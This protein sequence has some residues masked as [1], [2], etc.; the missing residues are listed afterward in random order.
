MSNNVLAIPIPNLLIAFIP[1]VMVLWIL[2]RW[3][4]DVNSAIYSLFRM[5]I[6]LLIVGY[7]LA[8][9]FESDNAW[10][11]L[12]VL[13]VMVLFSCW[14]A[15]RASEI[16]RKQLFFITFLAIVFGGGIA[17]VVMTQGVL[18]LPQWYMPR[19]LI[20]LAGMTFASSMNSISLAAER[21]FSEIK[22][23]TEYILA[24]NAAFKTSMIPIV[25]SMFAV[26]LVSLP[27]M[28]TGQILS[29]TS[30]LIAARY[31]I[32]VMCMLF[33]AS[34]LSTAMFLF[35]IKRKLHNFS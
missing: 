12:C 5:L 17:L 3:S 22:R 15:L 25:N 28:M 10:I 21:F 35:L 8:F 19:Y 16:N 26:G 32:M 6:Q 23:G 33:A 20:P 4:V 24:R 31:Q 29:G 14:I 18:Q 27:G 11:I 9:I 13:S 30:P 34:G 1:V 7:F 2:Y